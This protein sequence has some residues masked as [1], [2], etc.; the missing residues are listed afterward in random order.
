MAVTAEGLRPYVYGAA[1]SF[2]EDQAKLCVTAAKQYLASVDVPEPQEESPLYDLCCYML[3]S[4]WYQ[5]R[6]AAS[7]GQEQKSI[8][9]GVQVIIPQLQK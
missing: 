9:F 5:N 4:H 8:P 1:D 7:M 2:Q 3:A 6:G